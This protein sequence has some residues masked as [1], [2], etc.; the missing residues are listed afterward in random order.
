MN[1]AKFLVLFFASTVLCACGPKV[2]GEDV[3]VATASGALSAAQDP[4]H[5][6]YPSSGRSL[7]KV[8]YYF[9]TPA[10]MQARQQRF[11]TYLRNA[12]APTDSTAW[13]T[14]YTNLQPRQVSPFR[15]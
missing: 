15:Q 11:E 8:L 2:V 10:H 12:T 4:A 7:D 14:D 1:K 9:N 3:E 5:L 13:P 6:R